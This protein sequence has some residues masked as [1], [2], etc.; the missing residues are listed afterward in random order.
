MTSDWKWSVRQA[1]MMC[2]GP[3]ER[4]RRNA[5]LSRQVFPLWP[6]TVFDDRHNRTIIYTSARAFQVSLQLFSICSSKK[7]EKRKK[8]ILVPIYAI[9]TYVSHLF[10]KRRMSLTLFHLFY[11][12]KLGPQITPFF[13]T[14]LFLRLP[15]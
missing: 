12:R 6:S 3:G 7:K 11:F 1:L 4:G 15:L 5:R 9:E 10:C 8:Y 13:V 14:N 2:E